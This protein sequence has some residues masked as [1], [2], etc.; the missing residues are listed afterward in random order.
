MKIKL[1]DVYSKIVCRD[2]VIIPDI[3]DHRVSARERDTAKVDW[4]KRELVVIWFKDQ[5]KHRS[6]AEMKRLV[7][8]IEGDYSLCS[9]GHVLCQQC[10][11]VKYL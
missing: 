6:N 9:H 2:P 11:V 5:L 3:G 7:N 1:R 8:H 4:F 10:G